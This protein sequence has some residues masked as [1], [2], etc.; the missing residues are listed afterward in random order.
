MYLPIKDGTK[1]ILDGHG[2]KYEC[3]IPPLGYG[4]NTQ[5][6]A[7]EKTDVIKV[8]NN[9]KDQKWKRTELPKNWAEKRKIEMK[10]Q[11]VDHDYYNADLE[12]FRVQEWGR[13]L[14][15]VWF[16][17]NGVPT[18]ITGQN[19]F[20]INW[21][22]LD[23]IYPDYR[24]TD[25][26]YFYVLEY[27]VQDPRCAGLI[28][29]S[30]RRAGKTYKG[31]VFLF[32]YVSR[33]NDR[34]AGIQSKTGTDARAIFQNKFINSFYNLP[35]FFIPVFDTG[36]SV[37]PTSDL[38]F[39]HRVQKGA[40]A[41]EDF[42]KVELN[43][44]IDWK[45]SEVFSYDGAKL[46]RY[47]GDEVGKTIDVNIYDRHQV[48]K[49]CLTQSGKWIGKALYTT[50][51]EAMEAGGAP[52]KQLWFDSNPNERDKNQHTK[53]GLYTYFVPAYEATNF[54]EYGFPK[55]EDDKAFF[56]NRREALKD[57]PN[58]LSGEIRKN[59]FTVD[60]MF[61]IDGE[62]CLY[63]SMKLNDRRDE[64][65]YM[66]VTERGNFEWVEKDKEV[67]W[68]KHSN[69]RWQILKRFQFDEDGQRN[70]VIN[71]GGSYRPGNTLRFCSGVDPFDH[72]VT[73]DERRSSAA[74]YVKKKYNPSNPNDP[75]GGAYI[76]EYCARPATAEMMY[77]DI[78]KQ[79]FY[80]GCE[81][82]VETQKP[83]I[84]RYFKNRGYG[85]F[86]VI[87][88]GETEPGIASST[89][90]IQSI[91]E[92]TENHI[93]NDIEKVWFIKLIEDWLEFTPEKTTKFDRA[94]AW[95]YTEIADKYKMASRQT[96]KLRE[97]TDFFKQY[98][99]N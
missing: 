61:R 10:R 59:A 56:I 88:P 38:R 53:T 25:R 54:D 72:D 2:Y 50:T 29:A 44:W 49:Y 75:L 6:G 60:E 43:S 63:D 69:G 28:Y 77:E 62:K 31:T 41:L 89:K 99:Y 3:W 98:T 97:I 57:N 86:L 94:M 87:L 76:L 14:R 82:L 37:R 52:F 46:H 96:G 16:Y 47:L 90:T 30:N 27:C 78:L 20:Y 23:G 18:Y 4:F 81:L 34:Y 48:V 67:K 74:S 26:K 11:S 13:R 92:L 58:V 73:K 35:D 36:K 15:G 45:T 22:K 5:T 80:L 91:C 65:S 32:E 66:D 1:E 9:K 24:E 83:G 71:R 39:Q 7:I 21:W 85:A 12:A 55:I 95:G 64:L 84:M 8:S 33:L 40:K 79:C 93:Y 68:V 17:N 42:G 70:N 19:Y 51:V